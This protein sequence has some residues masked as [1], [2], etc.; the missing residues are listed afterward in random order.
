[1]DHIS[2][3]P[4]Q[5][6]T[7]KYYRHFFMEYFHGLDE[8]YAP[9]I[10][11]I[12]PD[13]VHPGK[14]DDVISLPGDH[15]NCITVP[16]IVTT[17]AKEIVAFSNFLVHHG[18]SH[19]N[20]NMGCP[21]SRLANKMRGCGI[22]PYPEKVRKILEEAI[23]H[24]KT[25]L[26][27]KVRL[28]Y[29]QKNE[30]RNILQ[31]LNDFPLEK[32]IIHPRTGD[33]LYRGE[34][35][36]EEFDVCRKKSKN[37]VVYNGNIIHHKKFTEL[38]NAF[39]EI[40]HWMVGRGALINPFLPGEI[41]GMKYSEQQKRKLIQSFHQ[42][43]LENTLNRLPRNNKTLGLMKAIW[44]YMSGSFSHGKDFFR[45]IKVCQNLTEYEKNV[46]FLMDNKFSGVD[47]IE[48]YFYNGLK[49]V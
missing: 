46:A 30:L 26:S 28:G 3:A 13:K 22:L 18:Y 29:T 32:V 36:T 2:L 17:S 20:W 1:M 15:K 40:T 31:V 8:V 41:K 24:I 38:K 27:V 44:Y 37:T 6:I 35:D 5:G 16:Q 14:F 11:G 7:H 4:F 12:H 21:F 25:S 42:D 34:P 43:L 49:H 33:Q 10:S 23:P 19:I 45:K 47:E 48:D 39:P 9:F